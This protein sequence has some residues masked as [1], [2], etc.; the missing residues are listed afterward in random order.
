M[1]RG[2]RRAAAHI[3]GAFT[4]R[5]L[6]C[7]LS[8][9]RPRLSSSNDKTIKLWDADSGAL[10]HTFEGH[11][12]WV[13]PLA[14]S[15]DG[16]RVLSGSWDKTARL[17]DVATGALLRTFEGHSRGVASVAFSPDG[18]RVLSGS[19]RTIR[20]WDAATGALLRSFEGHPSLVSSAALS[21]GGA[22]VLSDSGDD[23]ITLPDMSASERFSVFGVA[24]SPDGARMLSG[25]EGTIR[26][27]DAAT[28]ALLSTFE[29]SG[30]A[31]SVVFSPD[32]TRVLAGGGK[33][34]AVRLWDA[35]T[36]TLVRTFKGHS[37]AVNSVAFSP[38]GAR[39][40]S[41]SRDMT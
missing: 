12:H 15:P 18:A 21:S 4:H 31:L 10:L 13:E 38:D 11:S 28:G 40:L 8:R 24:F 19:D 41:G 33:D 27:W 3:Q 26:L 35:A 32:G 6:G 25:G 17:W 39:V 37:S 30:R 34:K 9:R 20:L 1:G 2:Y 36:G 23:S 14:F 22:R 29:K 5:Q 7:V 16:T